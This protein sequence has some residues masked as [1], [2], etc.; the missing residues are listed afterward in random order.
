M[1]KTFFFLL[2]AGSTLIGKEQNYKKVRLDLPQ[3]NLK[4]PKMKL[5]N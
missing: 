3:T 1:K 2:L 5:I 4:M